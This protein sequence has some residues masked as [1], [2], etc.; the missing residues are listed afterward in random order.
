MKKL[1][2]ESNTGS[3]LWTLIMG[4]PTAVQALKYTVAHKLH[5]DLCL[6][7]SIF[8]TQYLK[9]SKWEAKATLASCRCD[10]VVGVPQYSLD[11]MC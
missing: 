8:I 1:N 7:S 10:S 2:I 5:Q 3:A 4:H 6:V 11:S 9:F